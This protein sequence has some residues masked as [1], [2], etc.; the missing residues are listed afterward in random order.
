MDIDKWQCVSKTRNSFCIN[1]VTL[2]K[3]KWSPQIWENHQDVLVYKTKAF[4]WYN[5]ICYEY[6]K[7]WCL[8]NLPGTIIV[9]KQVIRYSIL[10]ASNQIFNNHDLRITVLEFIFNRLYRSFTTNNTIGLV[11]L[12]HIAISNAFLE[13]YQMIKQACLYNLYTYQWMFMQY[14]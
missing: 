10:K 6:V 7:L 12:V 5:T 8:L 14:L 4:Y 9:T 3:T 1:L 11:L 2:D 13:K